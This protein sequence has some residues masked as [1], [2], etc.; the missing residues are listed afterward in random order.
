L[1]PEVTE[2]RQRLDEQAET[3]PAGRGG[4]GGGGRRPFA[5][6]SKES[7]CSGVGAGRA[8]WHPDRPGGG[9][10][11]PR[12]LPNRPVPPAAPAHTHPPVQVSS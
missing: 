10:R 12:A 4:A 1:R 7:S 11:P 6:H 9:K 8:A 5:T 3:P 2:L